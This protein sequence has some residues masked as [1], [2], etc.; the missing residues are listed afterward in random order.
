MSNN[1]KSYGKAPENAGGAG[2]KMSRDRGINVKLERKY[3]STIKK[4]RSASVSK[5]ARKRLGR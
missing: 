1:Q 3:S 4:K 2:I 5:F